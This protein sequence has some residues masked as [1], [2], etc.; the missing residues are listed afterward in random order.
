MKVRELIAILNEYELEDEVKVS[1]IVDLKSFDEDYIEMGYAII[2]GILLDVD[3]SDEEE[4]VLMI[5]D[6]NFKGGNFE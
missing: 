1:A 4:P 5:Q 3:A 2:D 6:T